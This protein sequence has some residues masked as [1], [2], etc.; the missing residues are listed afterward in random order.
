MA[1]LVFRADASAE[2]GTG[3]VMRCLALAQASKAASGFA[4]FACA[5]I[6]TPLRALLE[7]EGFT[8][9]DVAAARGSDE[10]AAFTVELAQRSGAEW[11]VAD[12]YCFG[13][14][15]QAA[16]KAAG[17]QLLLIDDYGHAKRYAADYI[18]NQNLSADQRWYSNRQPYSRLLL[19]TK[20]V[21]LRREFTCHREHQ[22]EIA[23]NARKILI[24]V[25]GSDTCNFTP[26]LAKAL[27]LMNRAEFECIVVIG[28]SN[29]HRADVEVKLSHA[30]CHLLFDPPDMRELMTWAD[31]AVASAGSTTWELAFCGVPSLLVIAADNQRRLA[32][33]T[34]AASAAKN[35]GPAAAV[36]PAVLAREI[37]SLL[38]DE[39]ERTALSRAAHRLVD[40][41]G[42]DRVVMRMTDAPLRLSLA[43]ADDC[44]L[45]WQ[46]ANEPT[47]RA[48]AFSTALIPWDAHRTWF[49]AKL[50]DATCR[51]FVARDQD[52]QPVGQVR[53]EEIETGRAEVDI[54]LHENRRRSGLGTLLLNSAVELAFTKYGVH[55]IHAYIK[56]ENSVS[57]RLFEKAGFV[58]L[59]VEQIRGH[60]AAHLS[61]AR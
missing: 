3:H 30:R 45:L 20:Y 2:I 19:G 4:Q 42:V 46:W 41:Y 12:G 56:L 9:S 55:E 51:I 58:N 22:K 49:Q 38:R 11:V 44:R 43:R 57:L 7:R 23:R 48:M 40:G 25:G 18:L 34:N 13:E 1:N 21:L 50:R 29:P 17:Q 53:F 26:R 47:V 31:I 6:S 32:E 15:F 10:D 54:H 60:R 16:L 59:G 28:G 37:Q 27:D 61:R 39:A 33:A 24:T 14:A 8:V 52:D 35:L 5:S 36:E